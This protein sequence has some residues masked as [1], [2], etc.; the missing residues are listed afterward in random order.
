M[1]RT[2]SFRI[3]LKLRCYLHVKIIAETV[4]I[5]NGQRHKVLTYIEYRAVSGVFRTID[6]PP[7]LHP[8]SVS[9]PR[10]KGG[11]YTL[12][13]R[14]GGGGEGVN[15]SEDARHWIGLLQYNPSTGKGIINNGLAT[16][17]IRVTTRKIRTIRV[18]VI[19]G[20]RRDDHCMM[21]IFIKVMIMMVRKHAC[22][23]GHSP[24]SRE[25]SC[26]HPGAD[27]LKYENYRL[28]ERDRPAIYS[29]D[30]RPVCVC[31]F[32]PLDFFWHLFAL[33][34]TLLHL[35]P[36]RLQYTVSENTGIEHRTEFRLCHWQSNSVTT[37]LDLI[38]IFNWLRHLL[39][40]REKI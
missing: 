7:P 39:W 14:W 32:P 25:R 20:N 6:P 10:T 27:H 1:F 23:Q 21:I 5:I 26:R 16:V 40:I 22:R 30:T 29:I 28:N 35:P 24:G 34:S 4:M 9:S 2:F 37:R 12:A 15:I 11:G 19:I 38:H 13:G 36:L 18:M 3:T 31:E 8:A 33:Y 17:L